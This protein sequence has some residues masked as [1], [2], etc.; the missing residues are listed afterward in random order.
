[1]VVRVVVRW[2]QWFLDIVKGFSK[3]CLL[4][5]SV[6]D[7]FHRLFDGFQWFPNVAGRCS[8]VAQWFQWSSMAVRMFVQ[9]FTGV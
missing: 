3:V 8:K 9:G 1:M 4:V 7:D 6:F 2:F 5:F